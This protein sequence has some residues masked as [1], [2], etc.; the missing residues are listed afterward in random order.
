MVPSSSERIATR[1][2]ARMKLTTQ[3]A[4][5]ENERLKRER[6]ALADALKPLADIPVQELGKQNS[7]NQPLM[8]WNRHTIYVRDI[9]NA[10]AALEQVRK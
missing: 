8:G 10:R 9:L 6:D 5:A 7:P 1:K 4:H 2:G 3:E